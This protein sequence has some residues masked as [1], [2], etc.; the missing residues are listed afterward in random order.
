MLG[1]I[2][3]SFFEWHG[4]LSALHVEDVYVMEYFQMIVYQLHC[5]NAMTRVSIPFTVLWNSNNSIEW[6]ETINWMEV[7]SS[8]VTDGLI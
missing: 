3:F 6:E 1:M 4:N 2:S 5:P 7:I 8:F